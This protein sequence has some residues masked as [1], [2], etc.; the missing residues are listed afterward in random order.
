MIL[1]TA[2]SLLHLCSIPNSISFC[3]DRSIVE[4]PIMTVRTFNSK[5]EVSVLF[6]VWTPDL[7]PPELSDSRPESY[8][9]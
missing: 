5:V 2:K 1:P 9:S 8:E 6:G 4:F 3:D 7:R